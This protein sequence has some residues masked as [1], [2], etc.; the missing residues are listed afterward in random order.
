MKWVVENAKLLSETF[1]MSKQNYFDS[2]RLMSDGGWDTV[3]GAGYWCSL[4][5]TVQGKVHT[6]RHVDNGWKLDVAGLI[7]EEGDLSVM[8]EASDNYCG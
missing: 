8:M 3:A 1:H 4:T 2:L 7:V 6:I 5:R